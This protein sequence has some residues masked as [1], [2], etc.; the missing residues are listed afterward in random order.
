MA[1][2]PAEAGRG[3]EGESLIEALDGMEA[4]NRNRRRRQDRSS[5]P[6]ATSKAIAPP[7]CSP[8]PTAQ[9]AAG[10]TPAAIAT[11]RVDRRRS[12]ISTETYRQA[13]LVRQTALE[14]DTLQ[15]RAV[16]QRLRPLASAGQAWFGTAGEMVGI[17]HLKH[18]PARSRRADLRADRARTGMCPARFVQ[19]PF[20]WP[21]S[22][23]FDA[24]LEP[25]A[26]PRRGNRRGQPRPAA[27]RE[28]AE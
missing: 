26:Q 25:S 19:A 3:A 15:P 11:L 22:L 5:S 14:F 18:A 16:I 4:G 12:R 1:G 28:K 21:G 10:N 2:A 9:A 7:P 27:T 6:G 8:A 20:R 13:A 23:G 17:A 24:V